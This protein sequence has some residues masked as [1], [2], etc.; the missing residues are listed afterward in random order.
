MDRCQ[1]T[2][3]RGFP[4]DAA[5]LNK[6]LAAMHDQLTAVL[7]E[8]PQATFLPSEPGAIRETYDA[9]CTALTARHP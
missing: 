8:R 2:S 9:L 6:L 4:P 1:G 3:I 5:T 7:R